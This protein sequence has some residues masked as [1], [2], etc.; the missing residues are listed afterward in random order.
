MN[1]PKV[2]RIYTRVTQGLAIPTDNAYVDG[3]LS[4]IP[5][6]SGDYQAESVS[7]LEKAGFIIDDS[8][9]LLS[10]RKARI[11]KGHY[12]FR[13]FLPDTKDQDGAFLY[14]EK[15]V[16]K[17]GVADGS[18]VLDRSGFESVEGLEVSG[19]D[20][21]ADT[22]AIIAQLAREGSY[23]KIDAMYLD[24]DDDRH[25][26]SKMVE[27]HWEHDGT[28]GAERNIFYPKASSN[29]NQTSIRSMV[30]FNTYLDG[31]GYLEM[32]VRRGIGV[33]IT[34]STEYAK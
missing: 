9:S 16:V 1:K 18:L 31:F 33:N 34:I 29:D 32:P 28:S 12:E 26:N 14:P 17:I 24:A 4:N 20:Y 30:D 19:G 2:Q 10:T 22:L 25:Y 7:D 6:E 15:G 21:G 13:L 11:K 3:K 5:L 8:Y 23:F 27:R